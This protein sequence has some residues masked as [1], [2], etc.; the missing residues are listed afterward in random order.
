VSELAYGTN[1]FAALVRD[2][3]GTK[4]SG[5]QIRVME[6]LKVINPRKTRSGWRQLGE[7]DVRAAA[8]YLTQ[9]PPRKARRRKRA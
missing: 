3:C 4:P 5:P 6:A 2:L 8:E 9:Q 7:A 1:E